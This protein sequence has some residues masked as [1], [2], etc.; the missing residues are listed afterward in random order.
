MDIKIISI[1]QLEKGDI[2]LSTTDGMLSRLVKFATNS[3]YSHARIYTGSE[4]A[5]EAIDPIIVED[6]LIDLISGDLYT[7]VYR[8]RNLTEVQRLQIVHY[9]TQQLGKDYD[10]SGAI[11]TSN[12]GLLPIVAA[13]IHN[14]LDAEYDFYC[15]EL[16]A[17]AYKNARTPLSQSSSQ[18]TPRDLA[19]NKNLQYIGH[20]KIT[21]VKN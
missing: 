8:H 2:I 16:I 20:L 15:S 10:L 17:F 19:K 6:K 4:R 1:G 18:V 5:I 12:S 11:G 14:S 9:A 7:A 3:K 21:K 13:K